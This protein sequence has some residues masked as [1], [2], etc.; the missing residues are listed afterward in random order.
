MDVNAPLRALAVLSDSPQV[1]NLRVILQKK[2]PLQTAHLCGDQRCS[3]ST[4]VACGYIPMNPNLKVKYLCTN[5][6]DED[7]MPE[8]D[9]DQT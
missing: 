6:S 1:E 9:A 7:F 5:S 3:I 8:S 4:C 2:R